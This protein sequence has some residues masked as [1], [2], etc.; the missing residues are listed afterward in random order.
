MR[1]TVERR[2]IGIERGE[3]TLIRRSEILCQGDE[4]DPLQNHR[5]GV[6][7]S[8]SLS[9]QDCNSHLPSLAEEKLR[10]MPIAIEREPRP[11]RPAVPHSPQHSQAAQLVEPITGINERSDTWLSFL[12]EELKG[13]QCPLSHFTPFLS[14][15]D[16]VLLL[17]HLHLKS[18]CQ[19]FLCFF[20]RTRRLYS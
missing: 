3:E 2:I 18:R 5:E 15:T 12:S 4:G 7:L 20:L 8:D 17:L 1:R 14:L 10:P 11:R 13:F 9:A 16:P 19:P 6:T